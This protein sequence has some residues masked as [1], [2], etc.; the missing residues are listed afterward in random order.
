MQDSSQKTAISLEKKYHFQIYDRFPVAFVEG[1][2]ARVIDD[3][4]KEYIDALGGIAVNSVGHCHPNVVDAIKKQSEKIIHTSNFYY[5][6]PQ[7]KLAE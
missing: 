1:K 6:E 2:G 5:N 7:S 4:G 3:T